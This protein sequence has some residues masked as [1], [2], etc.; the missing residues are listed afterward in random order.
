MEIRLIHEDECDELGRITVRAYRQLNGS[1]PIGPYEEELLAVDQRR[2]DSEVYVALDDEDH[3]VGGVTY[4]PGPHHAMAEF[5]DPDAC[6]IRMLAIDPEA[7]GRGVGRSLVV[8]CIERGR[9]QGRSRI[10]LH[11]APAMTRAQAMY[12]RMGFLHA[13]ELD[14][15]IREDAHDEHPLHLTAYVLSL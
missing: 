13:P 12:L 3:V 1:R 5:R 14:E 15:W 6:G 8:T 9:Q 10:I 11:S 4:V 2:R 7:Q